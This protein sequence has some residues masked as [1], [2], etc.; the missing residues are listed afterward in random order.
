MIKEEQIILRYFVDKM[1][2]AG[3]KQN[4][5]ILT[6]DENLINEINKVYSTKITLVSVEQL[7]NKLLSGEYIQ[8][9]YFSSSCLEN[10]QI[11]TKGVG[12]VNS[13]EAKE[14]QIKN[15]SLMKKMSDWIEEHKGLVTVIGLLIAFITLMFKLREF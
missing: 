6:F 9:P 13:I 7:I 14:E 3:K 15:K 1:E 5:I 2:K 11:T 8:H 10:L 12:V 4:L